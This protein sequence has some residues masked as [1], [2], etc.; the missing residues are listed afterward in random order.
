M[1]KDYYKIL[2]LTPQASL[3]E[4]RKSFRRLAMRYHPDKHPEDKV[5]LAHFREIQEAYEILNDP[6]K[7]EQY[8]Q[9]RWYARSMGKKMKGSA[10]P[11]TGTI[12]QELLALEKHLAA[13]DP[14]RTHQQSAYHS[15][16]ALLPEGALDILREENDRELLP[17]I[18]RLSLS[19]GKHLPYPL[20]LALTEKIGGL[21]SQDSRGSAQIRHYLALRKRAAWWER[22]KV[23]L[24]LLV[25]IALCILIFRAA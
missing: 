20:A 6:T 10:P 4:I 8:H 17:E 11:T 24:L 12:L 3:Q 7:R 23:P 14:F 2:E 22:W 21:Y 9:E 1:L 25:T 19:C 18:L 15:L 5:A 16:E 13:Q